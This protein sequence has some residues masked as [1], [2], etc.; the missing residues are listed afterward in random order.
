MDSLA[1]APQPAIHGCSK[2]STRTSTGPPARCPDRVLPPG[3]RRTGGPRAAERIEARPLQENARRYSG[4]NLE[5]R[6]RVKASPKLPQGGRER[7]RFSDNDFGKPARRRPAG[8]ALRDLH[9]C[10]SF[11]VLSPLNLI[12]NPRAGRPDEP[13]RSCSHLRPRDQPGSFAL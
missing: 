2:A 6:T 8:K 12:P 1:F 3:R 10:P 4:L 13:M 9:R 7:K 11:P 5:H